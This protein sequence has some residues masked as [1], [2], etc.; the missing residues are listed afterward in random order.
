MSWLF[1][2]SKYLF[3]PLAAPS[4]FCLSI[5][6]Q[7]RCPSF[8]DPTKCRTFY[9]SP[10]SYRLTPSLREMQFTLTDPLLADK[11]EPQRSKLACSCNTCLDTRPSA[12]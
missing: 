11:T 2:H 1:P 6:V 9:A 4:S 5:T 7:K 3:L 8:L 12:N 10:T